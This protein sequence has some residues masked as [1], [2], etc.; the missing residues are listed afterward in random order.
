MDNGPLFPRCLLWLSGGMGP[1]RKVHPSV[2]TRLH[3]QFL[4]C[5]FSFHD[6]S[7]G[8]STHS[9]HIKGE[10]NLKTSP[11]PGSGC[12]ILLSHPAVSLPG[13]YGAVGREGAVQELKFPSG[14]ESVRDKLTCQ[15]KKGRL[16]AVLVLS[17]RWR[18]LSSCHGRME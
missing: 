8:L 7:I 2:D 17:E 9:E 16:G 6:L 3:P 4:H 18:T 15:N 5:T 14:S 10:L 11:F 13:N 1:W 12:L